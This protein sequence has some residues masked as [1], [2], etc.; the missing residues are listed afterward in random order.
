MRPALSASSLWR[1]KR[2][3]AFA[4]LQHK[5][6][7]YADAEAGTATHAEME[8]VPPAGANAEV[9][10][11]YDVLT[12]KAREIGRSIG[13]EYGSLADSEIPGTADVL[14]VQG[15]HVL[16][17]DYKSGNGYAEQLA[18]VHDQP[19]NNLQLQHNALCAA[20]VYGKEKAFVEV[21]YLRTGEV[22]DAAFDAFD[23]DAIAARLR[24]IWESTQ[25][26]PKPVRDR[27]VQCW[28]CPAKKAC[29]EWRK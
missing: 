16:I 13:R 2:C 26:N 14:H 6:E 8:K 24:S 28:R 10:F 18:G 11:A 15:D 23:L 3:P 1:A 25:N 22:K 19:G 12:R 29:P 5:T 17:Q 21:I 9:A 4:V 27:G 20:K 7:K